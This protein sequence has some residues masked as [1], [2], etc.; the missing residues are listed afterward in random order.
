M[1]LDRPVRTAMEQRFGR[2]FS[3]V[4]IHTGAE[5]S[6]AA[7]ALQAVALTQGTDILFAEG[8]Y[9]PGTSRGRELLAHE[10]THVVQQQRSG[11]S[12]EPRASE[13]EAVRNAKLVHETRP[14]ALNVA[15]AASG[16]QRQPLTASSQPSEAADLRNRILAAAERC[17]KEHG[18]AT[19]MAIRGSS[20]A[21]R[22]VALYQPD[23]SSRI[24]GAGYSP[25][26]D[27]VLVRPE[28]GTISITVGK[29]FVLGL[30]ATTIDA[31]ALE[32]G[33]AILRAAPRKERGRGLLGTMAVEQRG[34]KA[35]ST[36]EA[37]PE[38]EPEQKKAEPGPSAQDAAAI[39]G[40]KNARC[41]TEKDNKEWCGLVI[42][43]GKG[44]YRLTGPVTSRSEF[45]CKAE[46]PRDQHVVA[47]Y[48]SHPPSQGEDFSQA[49]RGGQTVGDRDESES[50]KWVWYVV[51]SKG[52]MKRYVPS[53]D[54]AG[55][56]GVTRDIGSAPECP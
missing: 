30:D 55:G 39:E 35:E 5:A 19:A 10:L 13:R 44:G 42:D 26:L 38:A 43:T 16:V 22:L 11:A 48:H 2:D 51:G 8:S 9:A 7:R 20:I 41:L 40:L 36:A 4:R 45:L 1:A 54:I 31:R 17:R 24:S 53:G 28:R 46:A 32:L 21:Y 15:T 37:A 34:A 50:K 14:R 52:G 23:Y 18:D 3:R 6:A 33:D 12:G 29:R 56:T 47:Y 49:G 27:G 25:A